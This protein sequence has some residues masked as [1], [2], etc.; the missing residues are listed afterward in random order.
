MAFSFQCPVYI[1]KFN[2][3]KLR[4]SRG[5]SKEEVKMI[6]G[7]RNIQRDDGSLDGGDAAAVNPSNEE[8]R[9]SSSLIRAYPSSSHIEG[10]GMGIESLA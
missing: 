7:D 5:C 6:L 4:Y 2:I 8:V 3:L 1:Y 10:P 9:A